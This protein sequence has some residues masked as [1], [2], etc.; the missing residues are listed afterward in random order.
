MIV[1][2]EISNIEVLHNAH[3]HSLNEL[4]MNVDASLPTRVENSTYYARLKHMLHLDIRAFTKDKVELRSDLNILRMQV[5]ES[6]EEGEIRYFLDDLKQKYNNSD[7]NIA[8]EYHIE[9]TK[10]DFGVP[11]FVVIK[12]DEVYIKK[13]TFRFKKRSGVATTIDGISLSGAP[14]GESI[15]SVFFKKENKG[16]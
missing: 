10:I 5:G 14:L 3:R 16:D 7:N 13:F 12:R 2:N 9:A 1:E 15:N 6:L 11:V 4:F 8:I